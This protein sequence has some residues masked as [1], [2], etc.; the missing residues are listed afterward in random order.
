LNPASAAAERSDVTVSFVIP[1]FDEQ[2]A[3]P[4]ILAD[5]GDI[6]V[7]MEILVVD[8]GSTDRTAAVARK[9]GATVIS[10][11]KGRGRQLRLGADR[12]VGEWLCFLHADVRLEAS[13]RRIL[14]R[15]D[16]YRGTAAYA[17][18]FRI[19]S[20]RLVYRC[21]EVGTNLRSRMLLLPYGDQG[22][23]VRRNAYRDAGGFP[24]S[25][26]MEDVALVRVLRRTVGIQILPAT[27]SVSARRWEEDGPIR[28][29]ARNLALLARYYR[30]ANPEE[31]ARSYRTRG[32]RP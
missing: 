21:I 29:T 28:R 9:A 12:A 25:P 20:P 11:P 10:S 3:L 17:F 26:I 13:A 24:D 16:T 32:R 6:D 7:P 31:L 4:G 19:A 8:G 22:L 15:G 5:L 1:A 27:V 2:G 14:S 18:R 30:G 23:L